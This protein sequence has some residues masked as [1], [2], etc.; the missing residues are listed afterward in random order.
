MALAGGLNPAQFRLIKSPFYFSKTHFVL[1][2]PFNAV[3]VWNDLSDDADLHPYRNE[4]TDALD[5]ITDFERRHDGTSYTAGHS[6]KSCATPSFSPTNLLTKRF[7]LPRDSR[8]R[9]HLCHKRTGGTGKE[10]CL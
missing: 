1:S 9:N 8:M 7:D 5:A 3:F 2:G 6:N 4:H 10:G